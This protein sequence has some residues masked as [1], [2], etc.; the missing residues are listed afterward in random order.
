MMVKGKA[1]KMVC[2]PVMA[3]LPRGVPVHI[4]SLLTYICLEEVIPPSEDE[5][6]MTTD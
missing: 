4:Q 6:V 2:C 1:Y 3:A 5:D